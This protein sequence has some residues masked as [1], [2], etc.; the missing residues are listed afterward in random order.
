M[1][2]TRRE[3]LTLA[4]LTGAALAGLPS[5]AFAKEGDK[6][7]A[8]DEA[9]ETLEYVQKINDDQTVPEWV[10]RGD[11]VAIVGEDLTVSTL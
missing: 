3:T 9:V 2:L 10:G 7:A 4:A 11:V 6:Y 1:K 5:I 8:D